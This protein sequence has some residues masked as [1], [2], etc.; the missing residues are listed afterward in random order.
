MII[1]HNPQN[2][3]KILVGPTRKKQPVRLTSEKYIIREYDP[4]RPISRRNRPR[5]PQEVQS[6]KKTVRS[7]QKFNNLRHDLRRIKKIEKG[8][9]K[10][11]IFYQSPRGSIKRKVSIKRKF[12]LKNFRLRRVRP[13]RRLFKRIR[14]YHRL[15]K[16]DDLRRIEESK[17]GLRKQLFRQLSH[18][19]F[20]KYLT[21]QFIIIKST[22]QPVY[23]NVLNGSME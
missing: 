22:H 8:L 11:E 13:Y 21:I 14:P 18:S 23:L 20:R 2:K 4:S 12:S 6:K 19:L 15:F 10:Q 9:R 7:V 3:P 1:K 16:I 5:N 17:K